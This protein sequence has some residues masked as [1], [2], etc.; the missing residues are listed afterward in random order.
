[1]LSQLNAVFVV[2]NDGQ[3]QS[4]LAD[5]LDQCLSVLVFAVPFPVDVVLH[6]QRA[7]CVTS[8]ADRVVIALLLEKFR[9]YGYEDAG[10]FN[11]ERGNGRF[12]AEIW[13]FRTSRRQS[14]HLTSQ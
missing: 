10:I 5:Q 9:C 7:Q 2:V 11:V 8:G 12:T 6:T 4:W 1:M 14:D 3:E 13:Y